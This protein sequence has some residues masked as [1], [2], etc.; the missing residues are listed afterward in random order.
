MIN[1][2]HSTKRRDAVR[3]LSSKFEVSRGTYGGREVRWVLEAKLP[4]EG[5][6][7][8]QVVRVLNEAGLPLPK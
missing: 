7:R 3:F 2:I 1:F 8:G 4:L 5:Y 6:G